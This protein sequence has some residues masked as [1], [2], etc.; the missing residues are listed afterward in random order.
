MAAAGWCR[1]C[2]EQGIEVVLPPLTEYFTSNFVN[3][4]VDL[5]HH[6]LRPN[7]IWALSRLVE[8]PVE[9]YIRR[10]DQMMQDFRFYR[11][12]TVDLAYG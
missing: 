8:R 11:P 7:W 1:G 6:L 3:W 4:S 2:I 9:N 12:G 10:I 5:K